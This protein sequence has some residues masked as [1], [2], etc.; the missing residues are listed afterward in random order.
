MGL[1]TQSIRQNIKNQV[2][3]LHVFVDTEMRVHVFGKSALIG[4]AVARHGLILWENDATGSA[5]LFK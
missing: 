3:V 5:N 1:P 2:L 4:V